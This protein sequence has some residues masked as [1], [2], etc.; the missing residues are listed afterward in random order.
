MSGVLYEEEL[1]GY[2]SLVVCHSMSVSALVAPELQLTPDPPSAICPPVMKAMDFAMRRLA[3]VL[4]LLVLCSTG[5]VYRRMTILSEP[6]GARVFM[7]NVEVGTTPCNV[8]TNSFLDH[9]NYKFKLFK[10]G[11]E[12]LEVLEPVPPKWWEYPGI[13]FFA[14]ISPFDHRDRRIFTYQLQPMKE[15]SGDELKQQ[16]DEFRQRGGGGG[17]LPAMPPPGVQPGLNVQ[18]PPGVNGG[19]SLPPGAVGGAT[20][21][22]GFQPGPATGAQQPP[23]GV[24]RTIPVP[25]QQ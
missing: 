21:P 22:P 5:C 17:T 11:F 6:P 9:G 25:P 16:A 8:P 4:V 19:V 2:W 1:L 10:D 13:D 14:E 7:N 3:I 24:E 23:P 15:K 20:P 18:P 12:P